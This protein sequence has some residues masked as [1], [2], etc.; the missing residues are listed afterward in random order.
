MNSVWECGGRHID[1]KE[2]ARR[3]ETRGLTEENEVPFSIFA[4]LPSE[5]ILAVLVIF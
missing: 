1:S 2:W 4:R 5:N 3:A